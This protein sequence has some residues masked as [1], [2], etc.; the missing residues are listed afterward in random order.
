[1]ATTTPNFGWSVPTSSDLV[2][3]GATA[4]ETLGDSVDAQLWTNTKGQA[5][6]NILLNGD[7]VINQRNAT[8]VTTSTGY[9]VD[10]Y[11][12]VFSG[13]TVTASQETFTP[14][15]ISG[16]EFSKFIKVIV[17]GQSGVND[18]M[19]IRSPFE[20]IYWGAGQAVVLSFWAK[21]DSGTPQVAASFSQ[22]FGTG[23]S[24][25][26]NTKIG[27]V[28]LS[29]SWARY[30]MTVTMPS[31]TGKT[32]GT[33]PYNTLQFWMSAG[34]SAD[35]IS[36]GIGVQNNTFSITGLQLELGS[37]A[38]GF[39]TTSGGSPQ[40]ELAMCQ[41]YYYRQTS[42][43]G[44]YEAFGFG[45]SNGTTTNALIQVN[46]PA[47]MRTA[48]TSVEYSTLRISDFASGQTVTSLV[49]DSNHNGRWT[50]VVNAGVASGLT[51]SRS[52]SLQSNNSQSGYIGLSAE[53]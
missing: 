38:T 5:G 46:L 37:T 53:L 7:C 45:M 20:T 11:A 17:S 26:V 9:I 24:T 27:A 41:R 14:G 13:G 4:I 35:T 30:S 21:A 52:Y 3:N 33:S 50:G 10:R 36:L 51:A 49:I 2:K 8:S 34:A 25:G 40:A 15:T 32:I 43:N 31:I 1:M 23:G 29:T 18:F 6:K 39:S 48:P 42:I 16:Q 19:R 47:T 28:T 12:S 22:N 44:F